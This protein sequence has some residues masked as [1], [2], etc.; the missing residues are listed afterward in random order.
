MVLVTGQHS[1]YL[2]LFAVPV[3]LLASSSVVHHVYYTIPVCRHFLIFYQFVH[4]Y[5]IKV[6]TC[7][8]NT[9]LCRFYLCLPSIY[10]LIVLLPR[11]HIPLPGAVYVRMVENSSQETSRCL[12]DLG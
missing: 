3:D 6:V 7:L 12:I 11:A 1:A 4:L 2:V 10:A 8:Q 5:L 9:V